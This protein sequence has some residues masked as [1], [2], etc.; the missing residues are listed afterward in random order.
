VAKRA[1][2]G[3]SLQDLAA[4]LTPG[5]PG[6]G[7]P[8][9]SEPNPADPGEETSEV[10]AEAPFLELRGDDGRIVGKWKTEE[11]LAK[12]IL[13]SREEGKRK[14]KMVKS[15]EKK[16]DSLETRLARLEING[17]QPA[18]PRTS[19]TELAE[20]DGG[21]VTPKVLDAF[22]TELL[23]K[24]GEI[25]GSQLNPLVSEIQADARV[26]GQR[27]LYGKLRDQLGPYLEDNPELKSEVEEL[28]QLG[29]GDI[30]RRL[31]LGE[32]VQDRFMDEAGRE[33]SPRPQGARDALIPSTRGRTP[34]RGPVPASQERVR[35]AMEALTK[36][37][38]DR[39]GA[40]RTIMPD[41]FL[42]K[43]MPNAFNL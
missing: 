34:S 23:Q 25:V 5:Q 32:Y 22:G 15:Q 40:L 12:T 29:K 4:A 37:G 33:S 17:T 19:W 27:P 28:V 8:A 2:E 11:A 3:I 6:E 10:E 9:P 20:K 16:I 31:I 24:V 1:A 18:A 26:I 35:A 30:A 38:G 42:A 36:P 13:S 43:I 39:A 7:D 14:D 21:Y 41:E